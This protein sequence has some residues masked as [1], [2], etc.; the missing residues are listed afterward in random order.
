M[1]RQRCLDMYVIS[2]YNNTLYMLKIH[3]FHTIKQVKLYKQCLIFT[4]LVTSHK[5][6][7]TRNILSNVRHF[8]IKADSYCAQYLGTWFLDAFFDRNRNSL[9]QFQQ[10]QLLLLQ[11]Y[12]KSK[13]EG[14]ILLWCHRFILLLQWW[15]M[16]QTEQA[17]SQGFRPSPCPLQL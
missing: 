8:R 16:S 13:G 7:Q 11:R 2:K 5:N 4:T 6:A 1:C 3:I 9:Q 17:N 10:L 14:I 12:I 15:S